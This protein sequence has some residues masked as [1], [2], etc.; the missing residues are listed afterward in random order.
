VAVAVDLDALD[1]YVLAL[2]TAGVAVRRLELLASPGESMFF[3]LTTDS[4]RPQGEL[5]DL[6][7][8]DRRALAGT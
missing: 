4:E 2:G 6:A 3:A 1:P 5:E 7:E 8:L